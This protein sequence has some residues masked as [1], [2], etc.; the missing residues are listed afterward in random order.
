MLLNVKLG[1]LCQELRETYINLSKDLYHEDMTADGLH[2]SE[3]G[4]RKVA[5]R[6]ARVFYAPKVLPYPNVPEAYE[7]KATSSAVRVFASHVNIPPRSSVVPVEITEAVCDEVLL[8]G[9]LQLLLRRGIGVASGVAELQEGRTVVLVTNFR[10]EAQHLTKG[11]A[12]G[13]VEELRNSAE[14]A[15][16]TD[17]SSPPQQDSEGQLQ[18]GAK[19]AS[20]NTLKTRLW[21]LRYDT[22]SPTACVACG[23]AEETTE[24]LVLECESLSPCPRVD[25]LQDALGFRA[26]ERGDDCEE[27]VE[28]TKR[29]LEQWPEIFWRLWKSEKRA[30][31]N[32]QAE[33]GQSSFSTPADRPHTVDPTNVDP[34]QNKNSASFGCTPGG[35]HLS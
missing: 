19:E 10:N 9:S 33:A 5:D 24:H 23:A 26:A 29:R 34:Q 11:A 22:G 1:D 32:V 4:G 2:Y 35:T 21:R 20:R 28:T 25:R 31:P 17:E 18:D 13:H 8:E 16:I 15:D 30:R 3:E 6:L 7:P 27:H 12:V 14:I